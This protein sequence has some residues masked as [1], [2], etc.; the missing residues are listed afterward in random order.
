MTISRSDARALS[1]SAARLGATVLGG[2]LVIE[3]GHFTINQTDVTQLLERLA[4]QNV[5]LVVGRVD[6]AQE[7]EVKT[8]LT[9]GRDYTGAECPH[10]ARVRSRL[11]G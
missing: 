4:G 3:E 11:R 8:C 10:C 7:E 1:A 2:R 6:D 9:C 5:V